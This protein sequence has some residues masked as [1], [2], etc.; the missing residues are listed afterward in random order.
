M[1]N[2]KKAI[3]LSLILFIAALAVTAYPLIA[4][5]LA[6]KY[7]S[8]IQT[9][10]FEKVASMDT[11]ALDKAK[12]DAEKYN[13]LL[14]SGVVQ[15]N[16]SDEA[17]DLANVGYKN[18]VSRPTESVS[19]DLSKVDANYNNKNYTEN[20]YTYPSTNHVLP[21]IDEMEQQKI[22]DEV[23]KQ[24]DYDILEVNYPYDDVDS[25][26]EL[27]CDVLCSSAATMKIGNEQLSTDR[28][29]TRYRQLEYGHIEYVIDTL[30]K[31][32]NEIHNIRA[33]LLTALYNA[34]VTIGPYYSAAVRHDYG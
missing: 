17:L 2:N 28:V 16:Y 23:K 6:E 34:P 24:I 13:R 5:A 18:D 7:R 12:A 27:I 32:T 10:Y 19:A 33:Y 3:I 20:S 26:M 11:E 30:K 29:K 9:Q 4:N 15:N 14:N 25:F 21:V 8:E 31:T 1:N 22:R